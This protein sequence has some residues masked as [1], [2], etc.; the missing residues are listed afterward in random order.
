MFL[1]KLIEGREAA[2]VPAAIKQLFA[3]LHVMARKSVSYSVLGI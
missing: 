1:I 2:T 3:I